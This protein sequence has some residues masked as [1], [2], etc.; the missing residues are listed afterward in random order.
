[1]VALGNY[2][3]RI[4]NERQLVHICKIEDNVTGLRFG[5]FGR[6]DGALIMLYKHKGL[7]V[8]I[9]QRQFNINVSN[10]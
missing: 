3:L 8:K 6:E 5:T 10:V 1:M 7:D 2:E 4:Y 9:L